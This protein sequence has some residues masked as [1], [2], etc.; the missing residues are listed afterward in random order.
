MTS[1]VDF[2]QKLPENSNIY[3][4]NPS[5]AHWK[6]NLYLCL[7]RKFIRYP[8]LYQKSI[9]YDYSLN[10][11]TDP[12]H[13]W[14]GGNNSISWW[15]STYGEDTTGICLLR[16]QND[17]VE[18]VKQYNRGE[19]IYSQVNG[20]NIAI[21]QGTPLIQGVDARLLSIGNN[22]FVCSYNTFISN[23]PDIKIKNDKDCS[24]WCGLLSSRILQINENGEILLYPEVLLCP[25]ISNTVEKNWSFWQINGELQFSYGL[26]PA[27]NIYQLAINNNIIGCTGATV[28]LQWPF[29][30]LFKKFYQDKIHISVTTPAVPFESYFLGIGHIK[31]DYKNLNGLEGT[32][33]YNFTEKMKNAGKRFH[34]MFIYLMFFYVFDTN[35]NPVAISYMFL[36]TSDTALCF[37]SGLTL[38]QDGNFLVSYGDGDVKCKYFTTTKEIINKMLY[39]ISLPPYNPNGI[40]FGMID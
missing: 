22:K 1:T 12:N 11:E 8:Q 24:N 2:S 20:K 6:D 15:Q 7:Y 14:L 4:F 23:R 29:L 19:G 38:T 9:N 16:I 28:A 35:G 37:P 3:T 13:P 31:Y 34:P 33:L 26:Y 39:N 30:Q 21:Q 25:E 36:P 18:L 32:A 27:H 5:I 40:I 10:P 17:N